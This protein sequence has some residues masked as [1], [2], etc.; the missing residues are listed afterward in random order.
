MREKTNIIPTSHF[1]NQQSEIE[2]KLS[3]H[4]MLIRGRTLFFNM[5]MQGKWNAEKHRYNNG[6]AK[7]ETDKEYQCRIR[8]VVRL[9]AETLHMNRHIMFIGLAEAPIKPEDIACF[10]NEAKK[11]ISLSGFMPSMLKESFTPMGVATFINHDYFLAHAIHVDKENTHPSLLHRIQKFEVKSK[12]GKE[13]FRLANLH[14]PYD[15]AKS[16]NPSTLVNFARRLFY[17]HHQRPTLVMGDFNIYPKKIAEALTG[18]VWYIQDKNNI[19]V[20]ADKEGKVIGT[21][22]DTV[23]GILRSNSIRGENRKPMDARDTP[24]YGVDLCLEHRLFKP[25][26]R[27]QLTDT[28]EEKPMEKELNL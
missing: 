15:I 6:F 1:L 18:V 8:H 19:L 17:N 2:A 10:I 22:V 14:L 11:Y 13:R 28:Q 3:D 21:E 7:I 4:N 16:S 5:M 9:L 24:N 26:P 20:R 23:D 12:D 25:A 27:R